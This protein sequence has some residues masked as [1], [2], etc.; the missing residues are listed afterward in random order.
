MTRCYGKGT[1]T[2]NANTGGVHDASRDGIC[3]VGWLSTGVGPGGGG[4]EVYRFSALG[5]PSGPG[6]AVGK[7]TVINRREPRT[8]EGRQ[9]H[10]REAAMRPDENGAYPTGR[11]AVL[12]NG[13][14]A[15]R[16]AQ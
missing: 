11:E 7:P 6:L 3:V 16:S 15:N 5:L 10:R 8:E 12:A 4:S 13:R 2:W 1:Q 14:V 9:R